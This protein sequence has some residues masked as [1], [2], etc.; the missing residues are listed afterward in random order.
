MSF[1]SFVIFVFHFYIFNPPAFD[2][3]LCVIRLPIFLVAFTEQ[4]ILSHPSVKSA[5]PK[6]HFY[7][8]LILVLWLWCICLFLC[9]WQFTVFITTASQWISKFGRQ[10]SLILVFFR[11]VPLSFHINFRVI[12]SNIIKNPFGI[13]IIIALTL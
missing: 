13:L 4:F 12:L 5:L 1:K 10:I 3:I 9:Q 7:V 8:R 6:I 11:T 2:L